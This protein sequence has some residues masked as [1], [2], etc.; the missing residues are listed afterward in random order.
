[1][2]VWPTLNECSDKRHA[3]CPTE[4]RISFDVDRISLPVAMAAV[5]AV[6]NC[7]IPMIIYGSDTL[8]DGK[9]S[10][11]MRGDIVRSDTASVSMEQLAHDLIEKKLV[12]AY[13]SLLL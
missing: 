5:A 4:I 11:Y 1:M 12:G 10:P 7:D 3:L 8:D 9:P 13:S 6:H 2:I